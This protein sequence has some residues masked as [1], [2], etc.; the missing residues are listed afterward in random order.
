M[1]LRELANRI[2]QE[3]GELEQVCQRVEVGWQRA[4]RSGDDYYLDGVALNLHGVYNGLE[5]LFELI[6]TTIDGQKPAGEHWHQT[7]LQQ[8]AQEQPHIRPAIISSAVYQPLDDLRGFR[9]VV[10]NIYTFKFNPTKIEKLVDQLPHLFTQVKNEL[11]V[12]CN[13]LNQQ[14]V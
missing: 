8:M 5:R 2:Q 4:K 12:F 1:N 14:A 7:L 13:F 10:R 11:L 9:H 6:A 3:L